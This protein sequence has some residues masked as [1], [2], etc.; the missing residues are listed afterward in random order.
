MQGQ[1]SDYGILTFWS[2]PHSRATYARGATSTYVAPDCSATL[3]KLAASV[4]LSGCEF[5]PVRFSGMN[6]MTRVIGAALLALRAFSC[7]VKL[8]SHLSGELGTLL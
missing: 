3:L 5:S 4:S 6:A 8:G 7:P 2:F 1:H